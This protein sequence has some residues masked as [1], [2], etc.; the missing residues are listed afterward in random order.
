M[1]NLL[2]TQVEKIKDSSAAVKQ[3][4]AMFVGL[5]A[6]GAVSTAPA[7]AAT[8]TSMLDSATTGII[9]GFADN[10]VPTVLGL[11]A[12]VIPVWLALWAISFAVKKGLTFLMRKAKSAL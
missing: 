12:I 11:I 2:M 9:Q 7:Y 4:V 3:R 10:L 5:L 6:V 8:G 1:K